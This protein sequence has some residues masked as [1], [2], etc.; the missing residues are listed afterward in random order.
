MLSYERTKSMK[1]VPMSV[2][3]EFQLCHVISCEEHA[4]LGPVSA[5]LQ[6]QRNGL[7]S[8]LIMIHDGFIPRISFLVGSLFIW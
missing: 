2:L 5:H 7:K 8:L 3:I 6:T 4:A 1:P